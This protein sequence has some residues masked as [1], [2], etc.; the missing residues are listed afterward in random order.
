MQANPMDQCESEGGCDWAKVCR[1]DSVGWRQA[2]A[3]GVQTSRW[4]EV[5]ATE[6]RGRVGRDVAERVRLARVGG[7]AAQGPIVRAGG[8]EVGWTGKANRGLE[9]VYWQEISG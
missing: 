3:R 4:Q 7:S 6:T 2:V 8:G 1:V 9:E 5:R